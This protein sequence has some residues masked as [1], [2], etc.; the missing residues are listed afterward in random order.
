MEKYVRLNTVETFSQWGDLGMRLDNLYPQL[1]F[2]YTSTVLLLT[3][4]N[5]NYLAIRNKSYKLRLL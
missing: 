5:N 3:A 4:L 1:A 2:V